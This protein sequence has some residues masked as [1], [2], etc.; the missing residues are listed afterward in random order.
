ML[1]IPLTRLKNQQL[2]SPTFE[3]PEDV[4]SWFG[5]IQAQDFPAAKWA[6]AL[7]CKNA[8]DESIEQSFNNGTILRTHVM[9]PTWHF[10]TPSD[11]RWLL[12]LTAHRVKRFNGYYYRQ[13]GL[14]KSIF[15]KSNQ[16][17]TN[18]LQ[19]GKQLTRSELK[20]K[21]VEAN[22]PTENL[23]LSYTIM[24]AEL[25]GLICSGPK[26]NKQLTYMLLDERVPQTEILSTEEALAELTKRYFQSHGPAHIRDFSWW[27][28]MTLTDAKKGIAL[29]DTQLLKEERDGKIYFSLETKKAN[30]TETAFLIP[31]FDEYFIAYTDRSDVLDKNYAKELNQGGGMI[32]GAVV[33]NGRMV[34]GWKRIFEKKSVVVSI[35]LFEK[36]T[37]KQ[38]TLLTQQAEHFGVFLA[39]PLRI[40]IL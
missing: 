33:V 21:L 17:I 39:M 16:I 19:D 11:I 27:S 30:Q 2:A 35:K 12:A 7:R 38:K 29:L 40:I 14:D 18:A 32:N 24:Q 15:I 8:T 6:I 13:T 4:I 26:K 5:A 20:I 3:K 28:G 34:G 23:G 1:D 36:I 31:G 10:V 9:R 22:I 37:Y 25:D